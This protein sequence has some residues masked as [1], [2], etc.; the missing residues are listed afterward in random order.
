MTVC[1]GPVRRE[2]TC[3]S[4]GF[5]AAGGPLRPHCGAVLPFH[6]SAFTASVASVRQMPVAAPSGDGHERLHPLP[7]RLPNA[8]HCSTSLKDR[9]SVNISC[10]SCIKL[11]VISAQCLNK[12]NYYIPNYKCGSIC[13]KILF[14]RM[15]I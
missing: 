7:T 5:S 4:L 9:L 1:D 10:V 14:W 8:S 3:S 15:L 2:M 11:N 12:I 13:N 6:R